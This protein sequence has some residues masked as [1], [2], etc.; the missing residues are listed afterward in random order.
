[1]IIALDYRNPLDY[2]AGCGLIHLL[3]FLLP[4]RSTLPTFAWRSEGLQVDNATIADFAEVMKFIT[5]ARLI[6]DR[7]CGQ[8][9]DSPEQAFVIDFGTQ[10]MPFNVWLDDRLAEKSVFACGAVGRVS[11]RNIAERCLQSA[12][13]TLLAQAKPVATGGD[14]SQLFESAV[15][16]ERSKPTKLDARTAWNALSVGFSLNETKL[17]DHLPVRP[18]AELCALIGAQGFFPQRNGTRKSDFPY[19]IW[20]AP[21]PATLCRALAR[22]V[23]PGWPTRPLVAKPLAAG[24][25][26]A[27]T[28]ANES[29]PEI[30]K[31]K[32]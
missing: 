2:L 24:N 29:D 11:A 28:F 21:A 16:A 7:G 26:L 1:M 27:Y 5:D 31:W 30:N 3:D 32:L 22:G 6:P 20:T 25:F 18:L 17:N 13:E 10:R 23:V 19:H 15:A 12:S 8:P 9:E 14:I 4:A